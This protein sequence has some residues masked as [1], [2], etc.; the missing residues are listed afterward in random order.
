MLVNQ[1]ALVLCPIHIGHTTEAE[2]YKSRLKLMRYSLSLLRNRYILIWVTKYKFKSKINLIFSSQ[3]VEERRSPHRLW[4]PL[5]IMA[6][7]VS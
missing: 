5:S 7:T 6:T 4:V 2:K 1:R 3:Y